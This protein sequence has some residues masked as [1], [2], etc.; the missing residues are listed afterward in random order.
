MSTVTYPGHPVWG[1]EA[2]PKQSIP[3]IIN[4]LCL[5][6][7]IEPDFS[8]VENLKS[9]E[10]RITAGKKQ[11]QNS[12]E[13][14]RRKKSELLYQANSETIADL[15]H[16][17]E[18][19]EQ[20]RMDDAEAGEQNNETLEELTSIKMKLELL[21]EENDKL[22]AN[23]F[24]N[25]QAESH[26]YINMKNTIRDAVY[27]ECCEARAELQDEIERIFNEASSAMARFVALDQY[28][29][30]TKIENEVSRGLN[31]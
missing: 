2:I 21:T 19:L 24:D 16:R 30:F 13:V 11:H 4:D 1:T 27:R 10:G 25:S 6:L 15:V 17:Q 29:D 14:Q 3:K 26:A 7:D 28:A 5:N 18:E 12:L 20:K 23:V 8:V 9:I 22:N 31:L